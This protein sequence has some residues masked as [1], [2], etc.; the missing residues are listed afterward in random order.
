LL[1]QVFGIEG[2]TMKSIL[3]IIGP[4]PRKDH[5]YHYWAKAI[6]EG[7]RFY[8]RVN[9]LT[10]EISED[11]FSNVVIN[12]HLYYFSTALK[13]HLRIKRAKEASHAPI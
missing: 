7:G 8:Y 3:I 11:E 2:L 12:P 9:G 6:E 4:Y 1:H 10:V 5:G 13:L